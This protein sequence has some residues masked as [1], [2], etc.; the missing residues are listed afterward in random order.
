MRA[1]QHGKHGWLVPRSVARFGR[2][3]PIRLSNCRGKQEAHAMPNRTAFVTGGTGFIGLNLVEH[4]TQS[5]WDVVALHRPNS[6]LTYLQ[7][8]PVRLVEGAIEDAE[9]LDRALPNIS[10]PSSTWL[11]M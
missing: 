7:K 9:S 8:Y 5:G 3:Q 4:L 2:L 11:A 10:M 6:K 1:R